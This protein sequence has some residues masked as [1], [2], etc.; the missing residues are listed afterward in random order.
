MN[1]L[2]PDNAKTNVAALFSDVLN[3][4][5]DVKM[6]GSNLKRL[7]DDFQAGLA[8]YNEGRREEDRLDVVGLA[9]EMG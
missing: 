7:N 6:R 4:V 5:M 3:G 1:S 8:S 2:P 9:V